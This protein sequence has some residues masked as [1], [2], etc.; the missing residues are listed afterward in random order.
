MTKVKIL[1]AVAC[2]VRNVA[3][4]TANSSASVYY[5]YQ[6]KVPKCLKKNN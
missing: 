4:T 5:V 1:K 3:S 6:P 2:V